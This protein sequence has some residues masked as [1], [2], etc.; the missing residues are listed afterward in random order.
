MGSQSVARVQ[1]GLSGLLMVAIP[2][3]LLAETSLSGQLQQEWVDWKSNQSGLSGWQLSDGGT[4][5]DGA[6]D[7]SQSHLNGGASYV[8][9]H[10]LQP[11]KAHYQGIGYASFDIDWTGGDPLRQ[12]ELYLGVQSE[13]TLFRVGQLSSPYKDSTFDWDP[14]A[15]TF[16]QARGNGGF[17]LH[18]VGY[19]QG[20]VRYDSTWWGA[21]IGAMFAPDRRDA[22]QN[23]TVDDK[24][25]LAFSLTYPISDLTLVTAY[26][27][28]EVENLSTA[29]KL[30]AQYRIEKSTFTLQYEQLDHLATA[31]TP[32]AESWNGYLNYTYAKESW[33]FLFGAGREVSEIAPAL[34][35][36]AIGLKA[37]LSP[38]F[39]LDTGYR[40]TQSNRKPGDYNESAVGVGMRVLF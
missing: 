21:K 38:N 19:F 34:N 16:M 40:L 1:F 17:S 15:A 27:K 31:T 2:L 29:V 3:P 14:M 13:R 33:L 26:E 18:H 4:Y 5:Q 10:H 36:Y 24:N 39:I 12:R 9:I 20:A 32:A 28:D 37:P 35:Y 30:A 11:L 6:S 22:N 23:Q 7:Q 25:S 8:A